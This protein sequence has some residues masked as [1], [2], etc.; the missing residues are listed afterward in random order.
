MGAP[1][2]EG[3]YESAGLSKHLRRWWDEP[4]LVEKVGQAKRIRVLAEWIQEREK[5]GAQWVGMKHPLLSLCGDD[6]VK[7][8]GEETRFIR[9]CRPLE[10]SIDSLRRLGRKL[11][12]AHMQGTLMTA[13]DQFFANREHLSIEFADLMSNPR[14]ELDR[15]MDYL[16]ITADDEKIATA[17]RFIEPGARSKVER[18]QGEKLGAEKEAGRK[19]VWEAIRKAVT[20]RGK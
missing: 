3:F 5:G 18:E 8:W 2:F 16:Q 15:L 19:T 10:D 11:D 12:G 17:L 13:L 9:C 4:H 7:A 20:G 14:R 6:L 1:F